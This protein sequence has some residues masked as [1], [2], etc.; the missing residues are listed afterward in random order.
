LALFF[1]KQDANRLFKTVSLVTLL[2]GEATEQRIRNSLN[3][4][5]EK[6]ESEDV[7]VIYFC[8]H[9]QSVDDQW[10][11]IPH[12]LL[13]PE[14]DEEV[15]NQGIS[16]RDLARYLKKAK[17]QKVLLIMDSC[18]SGAALLAFRGYGDRRALMQLARASGVYIIAVSTQDQYAAAVKALG[19]GVFTH[20]LLQGLY[21]NAAMG[22]QTMVTVKRL[23]AYVEEQLP[24]LSQQFKQRPQYPVVYSIGMD[25][26]IT[27]VE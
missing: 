26:P 24:L 18:K 1:K 27:V 14:R 8:G 11:F 25:F 13:R 17:A 7:L 22:G 3:A 4:V 12:D 6:T 2:D 23:L 9:G 5:V 16:S 20:T 15:L 19:H 21:G 10:Y